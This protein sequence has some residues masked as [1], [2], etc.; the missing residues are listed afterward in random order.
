MSERNL[1]FDAVPDRHGTKCLKYDFAVQRGRPADVLPLWVADMDFKTSSYIEDA[2]VRQA[3]HAIY[4]YTESD[5]AYFAAVQQWMQLH[6]DWR[7]EPWWLQKTPGVVFAI[8]VAVK[9]FTKPG[10]AVLIQQPVYYPF[11]EVIADNG[12][13]LISSDLVLDEETGHYEIDF[14]DFERKIEENNVKLFLLCSPHNPVGRVWSR[15][16][17][18][19]LGDI[20]RRHGVIVFSDEIHA[21]FVWKGRHQVFAAVDPA[22]AA[23]TVTA[24][25]PS[26]TFNIAGL[27]V[28]NIF[29][30]DAGLREAFRHAYNASGYSQLNAAGLIAAEAAYRDGGTWYNAVKAYIQDNIAY[31]RRFIQ[32]RLPQLHMI[33]PEGTYLV[34]VD[35]RSLGL[36]NAALEDLILN[37]AGLWLDSGAIFGAVGEGF[38]R[39]NVACPRATLTRALEQLAAAY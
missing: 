9:T 38:Q 33:E 22:F 21:D 15:E 3:Q 19:R 4:G 31:M 14:A 2:L 35:F 30:A 6:H 28:S 1:D 32:E 26:K 8:A 7:V 23:F 37:K 16:E 18:L 17:L 11:S 29:I 20:C 27:Q 5:D 12:R 34:W 39:F 24:T 10:D 13:R 36:D 25:A